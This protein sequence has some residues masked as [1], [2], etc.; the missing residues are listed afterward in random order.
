MLKLHGF[1]VSNYANMVQLALLEKGVPFEYVMTI[2]DQSAASLAKSPRGKVPFL[3]TPQGFLNETSAILDYLEERGEGKPLLPRR[4][5]R[6]R[7]GARADARDR[8]VHRAA[9][10]HLLRARRS[11]APRCRT[12]SRPRRATTSRPASPR[13]ERHGKFAPYVAGDQFTLADI[14]FLYSRRFANAVV[15]AAVRPR[16]AGRDAGGDGAAAAARREPQRAGHRPQPRCRHAWRSSRR[17]TPRLQAAQLGTPRRRHCRCTRIM[18]RLPVLD[19]PAR[20]VRDRRCRPCR[21]ARTR[22]RA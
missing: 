18:R 4:S 16:P 15:A 21:P 7:A 8:A 11:S 6:P 5:V 10:A 1:P 2:P 12:P 20:E 13:S 9:G 19:V 22:R 3:E 14:V 17:C